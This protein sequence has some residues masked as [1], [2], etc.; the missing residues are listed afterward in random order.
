M[1]E[2]VTRATWDNMGLLVGSDH[3]I[4]VITIQAHLCKKP[5]PTAHITDWPKFCQLRE[6]QAS[7]TITDIN[8]WIVPLQEHVQVTTREVE[9]TTDLPTT[10]S[11]LL[12]MWD[13]HAGLLRRWRWQRHSKKL[14]RRIGALVRK[15][16]NHSLALVREQW[17]QLCD[18]LN[19]QI[20]S[21][22]PLH[23]ATTTLARSLCVQV[24]CAK[25]ASPSATSLAWHKR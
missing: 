21:K 24:I 10:D 9:S 18:S 22:R 3:N 13:S 19:G 6:K 17:G 11:R 5:K 2:H 23:L 16:E 1:Q 8:E 7:D 14:Y 25:T 4:L 15:I 20:S 12:H